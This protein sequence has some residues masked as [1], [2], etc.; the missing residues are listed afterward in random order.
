ME[1]EEFHKAERDRPIDEC[2]L[3]NVDSI[4]DIGDW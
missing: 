2:R 1:A 3:T 4:G